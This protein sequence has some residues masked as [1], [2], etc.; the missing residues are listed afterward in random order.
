MIVCARVMIRHMTWNY[1]EKPKI[2]LDGN[3]ETYCQLIVHYVIVHLLIK[4]IRAFAQILLIQ[5]AITHVILLI[6][7][8]SL[9]WTIV[10]VEM[11][12]M[13]AMQDVRS[14][15]IL[16]LPIH[17]VAFAQLQINLLD[18]FAKKIHHYYQIF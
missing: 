8:T 2:V 4:N 3:K 12:M 11:Q 10:F 1:V 5:I 9:I 16:T 13:S 7:V 15:I 6:L 18:V 17:L 14:A